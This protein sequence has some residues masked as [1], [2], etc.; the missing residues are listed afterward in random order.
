[1][2][3]STYSGSLSANRLHMDSGVDW[4]AVMHAL[5]D[6]LII[7]DESGIIRSY[8]PAAENIFGY[9]YEEALGC[10]VS[11]LLPE[12][13]LGMQGEYQ[14][15][16]SMGAEETAAV[17]EVYGRRKSGELVALE[18]GMNSMHFQGEKMFVSTVRDITARKRL[19]ENNERYRLA[20]R[21][22][23]LGIWDWD[24]AGDRF[25]ASRQFK[26]M[27]GVEQESELSYAEF[28][29]RLHPEDKTEMLNALRDHLQSHTA[30]SA[31][32]RVRHEDDS[33]IWLRMLG[34]AQWDEDGTAIRMVGA[35]EDI[36][37]RKASDQERDEMIAKILASNAELERFAYVASH[38]MQEPIRIVT[39][40]SEII[41]KEH[42][43]LLS[44]E[45]K[46]F[47]RLIT[48]SG[49]RMHDMVED[50]LIYSRIDGEDRKS[51]FN[52]TDMLEGALENLRGL[53]SATK[54][55]VICDPL[56]ILYG[57]PVQ[58]M[59]LLQNLVGNGIK[60]QAPGKVP[61][62]D[63]SCVAEEE[64]WR[65]AISDNGIGIREQ[66][67]DQIFE[68]F[69][70]LHT[71][72]EYQGSGLGLAI[73]KRIVE[74]HGGQIQ[75]SSVPGEGSVFSFTLPRALPGKENA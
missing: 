67:L 31:E 44:A 10:N 3:I 57:N 65:I 23:G 27:L 48:D 37:W 19:E 42:Q 25:Y 26:A 41:T 13:Y 52:G 61:E 38:D 7:T 66:F 2:N 12:F 29:A 53:I 55:H 46:E 49:R 1:M 36:S 35:V 33:Y 17:R 64:Y 45:G 43:Q 58:I 20:A 24:V 60:Y 14:R 54:A 59:R 21:G 16:Y 63:I 22:F 51:V 68:P 39:N 70:R 73:C 4:Q 40:F 28:E 18:L 6:G 75:A 30:F 72:E 69:R 9:S 56:P 34:Q 11:M 32:C 8:N 62:I 50:L 47:L 71:W 15:H 5:P 74:R